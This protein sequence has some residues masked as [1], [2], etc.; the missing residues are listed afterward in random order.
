M[1][2]AWRTVHIAS[3]NYL[4][5]DYAFGPAPASYDLEMPGPAAAA[6][7]WLRVSQQQ[8]R[9][10]FQ[11]SADADLGEPRSTNWGDHHGAPRSAS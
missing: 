2:I 10:V 1:T 6:V 3:V 4:Y 11:D 7:E 9:A 5:Y 8:L